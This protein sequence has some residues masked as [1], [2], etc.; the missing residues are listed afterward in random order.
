MK[1]IEKQI[2]LNKREK[3]KNFEQ[4]WKLLLENT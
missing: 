3:R 1:N 2:S 4:K